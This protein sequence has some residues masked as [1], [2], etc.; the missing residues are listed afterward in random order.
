MNFLGRTGKVLNLMNCMVVNVKVSIQRKLITILGG[1]IYT[2][3][4][5]KNNSSGLVSSAVRA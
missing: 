1:F 2:C 4:F 5:S 3:I